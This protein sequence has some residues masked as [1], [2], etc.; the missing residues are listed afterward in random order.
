M[1]IAISGASGFIGQKITNH[2][3]SINI[4]VI[5]LNR[6][7]F[8]S[9]SLFNK[10]DRCDCVINLA[11]ENIFKRWTNSHK[12]RI[13]S[14]RIDTTR[15]IVDCINRSK[16]PKTLISTSA[17]GYYANDVIC[18]EYEY[19]KGDDFL[20]EVCRKWESEAMKCNKMHRTVITRFAV[21]LDE[22]GGA[23]EK[24]LKS[25]KF[26]FAT[27]IGN[28]K[29]SF[30]WIALT[31]LVRA[32]EY[33]VTNTDCK[34]IYNLTAPLPTTNQEFTKTVAKKMRVSITLP[35]PKFVFKIAMGKS[36]S[37]L[38]NG[39]CILPNRL[40]QSGFT[41]NYTSIQSYIASL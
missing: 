34:G 12:K 35:I 16:H 4:D 14:S 32:I 26:G 39:Q 13:L 36:S 2:L 30:S 17:I 19:T 33:L 11:G 38:T 9:Y 37:L 41:F 7:D 29:Q 27:I 15:Q 22:N 10:I 21:V 18:D 24:I 25:M 3:K 5:A 6:D 31:D 23:L 8:N 1:T 40:S 28:G 20:A